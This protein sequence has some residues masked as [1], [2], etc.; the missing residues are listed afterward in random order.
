MKSYELMPT[1]ENL[2]ETYKQDM[3]GR[4][5]KAFADILNNL[6]NCTSIAL[7]GKWGSGKTFFVK[8][9]KLFLDE[10]NNFYSTLSEDD[11]SIFTSNDTNENN[12]K[13][14][15][16]V[17]YDA[18][19]N[20]NDQDPIL[21]LVYSIIGDIDEG[22]KLDESDGVIK[23]TFAVLETISGRNINSTLDALKNKNLLDE[24]R[25]SKDIEKKIKELKTIQDGYKKTIKEAMEAKG[26]IKI[27]DEITGLSISYIAEQTNL[28][29]FNKEKF[30]EENPDLYDKYVTMDGKKSA[31]ITIRTK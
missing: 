14:Q 16:C 26:V 28:E 19:E 11:R 24:I 10:H 23:K 8:Q 3:L 30:Q 13:P 2:V 21:S 18:W 20:D 4:N 17:Y 15:V 5:I 1:H 12:Y 29:K 9:T 31:Y 22:Y 27:A 25:K 7:D 6:S